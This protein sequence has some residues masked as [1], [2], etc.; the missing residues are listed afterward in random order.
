VLLPY[1][2]CGGALAA[3]IDATVARRNGKS[4]FFARHSRALLAPCAERET[5]LSRALDGKKRKELRRQRKRLAELG[6]V[7]FNEGVAGSVGAA[8]DDFFSLEGSGYINRI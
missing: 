8:L 2:P 1:L 4:A 6:S 5:Y 7:T 3:A